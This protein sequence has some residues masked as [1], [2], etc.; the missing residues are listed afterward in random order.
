MRWPEHKW[1]AGVIFW[2]SGAFALVCL[3]WWTTSNRETVMAIFEPRN[4]IAFGLLV[5]VV[6]FGYQQIQTPKSVEEA[7]PVKPTQSAVPAAPTQPALGSVLIPAKYYSS[8]DKERIS[9]LLFSASVAINRALPKVQAGLTQIAGGWDKPN[10]D[11]APYLATIRDMQASIGEL[12][13]A[14]FGKLIPDNTNYN[15]ELNA[16]LQP[17]DWGIEKMQI[18][19]NEYHNALTVF[20]DYQGVFHQQTSLPYDPSKRD[21]LVKLVTLARDNMVLNGDNNFRN[22]AGRCKLRI[23]E[24]QK[25]LR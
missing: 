6:A 7:P 2:V 8:G 22:W 21:N 24:T 13:T 15:S 12:H 11:I 16:L 25:A 4:F 17:N 23:E 5:A 10:E 3:A 1:L 14:L 19:L 20:R 18:A 9:E